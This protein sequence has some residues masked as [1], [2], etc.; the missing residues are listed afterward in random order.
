MRSEAESI[1]DFSR[2]SAGAWE[3]QKSRG[4][5]G[6]TRSEGRETRRFE[7]EGAAGRSHLHL[8]TLTHEEEGVAR[9]TSGEQHRISQ[10]R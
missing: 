2:S 10:E 9:I 4:C 5:M 8:A 6:L 1:E 3:K 7:E